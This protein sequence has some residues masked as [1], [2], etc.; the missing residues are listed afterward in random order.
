M[1]ASLY[2]ASHRSGRATAWG[3][4][5]LCRADE[6]LCVS[7]CR[8]DDDR[9]ERSTGAT[10]LYVVEPVDDPTH[11]LELRSRDDTYELLRRKIK[12]RSSYDGLIRYAAEPLAEAFL[13]DGPVERVSA[14]ESAV[15]EC[16]GGEFGRHAHEH[17]TQVVVED[18]GD[19]GLYTGTPSAVVD[20]DDATVRVQTNADRVF[21]R[22]DDNDV[23]VGSDGKVQGVVVLGNGNDVYARG[24]A[25]IYRL[26]AGGNDNA[27]YGTDPTR[28]HG[29]AKVAPERTDPR[30]DGLGGPAVDLRTEVPPER[31]ATEAETEPGDGAETAGDDP[32]LLD[33]LGGG[34]D[35][36]PTEL[37][38]EQR[39]RLDEL[40]RAAGTDEQTPET[41]EPEPGV[42]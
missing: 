5:Y 26:S 8:R 14:G 4:S 30:T 18:G 13:H 9:S 35:D 11:A 2:V 40:K 12:A 42:E 31:L 3:E 34:R 25:T 32:S 36:E 21:V 19:V 39:R 7:G 28:T 27:L 37:T 22:G 6:Q 24:D 38:A 41:A 33:R 20:G 23:T 17:G 1:P 29:N 10:S 16:S 15:V